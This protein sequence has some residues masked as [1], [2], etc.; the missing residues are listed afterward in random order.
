MRSAMQRFLAA[1]LNAN[2][3]YGR[4]T[5]ALVTTDVA[6]VKDTSAIVYMSW[7]DTTMKQAPTALETFGFSAAATRMQ[8]SARRLSG[9]MTATLGHRRHTDLRKTGQTHTHTCS[10]TNHTHHC[11][12]APRPASATAAGAPR[13][14][15]NC[16]MTRR[17]S[18]IVSEGFA[19]AFL[20]GFLV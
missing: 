11:S 7:Y 4:E 18:R 8:L 19:A 2:A 16:R 13:P 5:A 15:P 1:L 12:P 6:V 10:C 20:E 14:R 3:L 9:S 17:F